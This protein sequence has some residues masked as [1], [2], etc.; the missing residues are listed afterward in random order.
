SVVGSVCPGGFLSSGRHISPAYF[1]S[2]VHTLRPSRCLFQS[3]VALFCKNYPNK[4]F[5]SSVQSAAPNTI[6]PIVLFPGSDVIFIVL[7]SISHFGGYAYSR[8]L[9][10]NL[11]IQFESAIKV[12]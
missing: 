3:S 1:T 6:T 7:S 9:Q 4:G 2:T 12:K 11:Q 8:V 5:V 10:E